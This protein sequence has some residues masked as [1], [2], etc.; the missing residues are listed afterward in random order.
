MAA[1]IDEGNGLFGSDAGL[2]WLEPG[3]DLDVK[4]EIPTLLLH[5]RSERTGNL[6]AVDRLDDIEQGNR[7]GRLVRLQRANQV[8]FEACCLRLQF[9][10]LAL[11]FLHPVF[12]EDPLAC[13][14]HRP[15]GIGIEGLGNSDQ[16]DGALGPISRFLSRL[17][18]AHDILQ[19]LLNFH[20]PALRHGIF[21]PLTEGLRQSWSTC[22]A[23]CHTGRLKSAKVSR[24]TLQKLDRQAV[25]W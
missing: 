17:N 18:P 5:F 1:E 11:S 23:H 12:T 6:V 4:P 21:K 15:N 22:Q 16:R 14:D 13:R 20:G 7:L 10:P 8:K 24:Q 3:V 19:P 9:R 2:L 25:S